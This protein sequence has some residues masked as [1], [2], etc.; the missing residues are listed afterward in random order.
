MEIILLEKI[1]GIS[2]FSN[3]TATAFVD[4]IHRVQG[5]LDTLHRSYTE[6]STIKNTPSQTYSHELSG[7][8]VVWYL[9]AAECCSWQE[10]GYYSQNRPYQIYKTETI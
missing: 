7:K 8:K 4:N 2:G 9:N 1:S 10:C 3:K 5:F 6:T